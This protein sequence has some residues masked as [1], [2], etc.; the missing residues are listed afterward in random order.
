M[1][2]P[3]PLL[4][5]IPLKQRPTTCSEI[6]L[7]G[8]AFIYLVNTWPVLYGLLFHVPNGGARGGIEGKQLEAS[9][10][11][12]GIPDLLLIWSG[13]HAI[14]AKTW[15][16]Q[17]EPT[18]GRSKEQIAIHNKWV[19]QGVKVHMSFTAQQIVDCVLDITGLTPKDS[20][21]YPF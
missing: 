18:L 20:P 2:Q 12:P 21:L 11:T 16:K 10:V 6:Q 1:S 5:Y 3:A 7:Q 4:R 13:L 14:E 17:F 8:D 19:T 9:G 15:D